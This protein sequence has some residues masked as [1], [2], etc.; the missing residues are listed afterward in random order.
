MFKLSLSTQRFIIGCIL[1]MMLIIIGNVTL[2]GL[3]SWSDQ[4][5]DMILQ[6]RI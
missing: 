2:D 4:M 1:V 5:Q 3:W 6:S